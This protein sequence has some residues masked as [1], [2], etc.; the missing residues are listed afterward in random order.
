MKMSP[1][2]FGVIVNPSGGTQRGWAILKSIELIF[3]AANAQLDAHVTT[4]AGLA[5]SVLHIV[6]ARPSCC[7]GQSNPIGYF[8]V[9]DVYGSMV[10]P[11]K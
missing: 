3:T 5:G 1:K 11:I 4:Q 9:R 2:R 6:R 7:P 8:G 10:A